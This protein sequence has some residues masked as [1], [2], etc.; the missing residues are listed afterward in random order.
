MVGFLSKEPYDLKCTWGRGRT[1]TVLLP[2]VFETNASTNSATQAK[3]SSVI[4]D[5]TTR[6]REW[7][8]TTVKGFADLCLATRPRDPDTHG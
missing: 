5:G 8:R 4:K 7:I 1:G 6:G 2:L 3:K